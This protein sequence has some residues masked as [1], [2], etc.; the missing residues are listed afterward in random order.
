MGN[1]YK[2]HGTISGISYDRKGCGCVDM[3]LHD[4]EDKEK[5]PTRITAYGA[6][7]KYISEIESTDAEERYILADWYYD[8][9]LFLHRIEIP[10]KNGGTPAKVITQNE[11]WG[12]ELE[13]FGPKEYIEVAEPESMESSERDR[14]AAYKF[15]HAEMWYGR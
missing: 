5:A 8:S 4:M 9:N 1:I 12:L 10:S 6:M 15:D 3:I 7:A 14:M 11:I 13:V 2:Y